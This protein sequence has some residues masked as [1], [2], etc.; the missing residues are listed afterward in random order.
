MIRSVQMLIVTK[1]TF[2]DLCQ[3]IY[4]IFLLIFIVHLRYLRQYFK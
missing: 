4:D 2:V 1:N 3:N